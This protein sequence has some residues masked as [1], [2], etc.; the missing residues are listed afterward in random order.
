MPERKRFD[1][2]VAN[3]SFVVECGQRNLIY[4]DSLQY[5]AFR[6]YSII[7]GTKN[8]SRYESVFVAFVC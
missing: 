4:G 7:S 2:I 1:A 8:V 3:V 6:S 5:V